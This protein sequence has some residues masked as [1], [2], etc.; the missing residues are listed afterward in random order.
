MLTKVSVYGPYM[1]PFYFAPGIYAASPGFVMAGGSCAAG[2]CG[3]AIGGGGCGGVAGVSLPDSD[4]A[5]TT[6]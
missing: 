5:L 6:C 2:T 1:Y 3:G 4:T